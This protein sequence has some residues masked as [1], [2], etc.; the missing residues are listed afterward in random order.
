MF[1]NIKIKGCEGGHHKE[2]LKNTLDA[3]NR[4]MGQVFFQ[5]D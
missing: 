4:R 5:C 3:S 1:N 2:K